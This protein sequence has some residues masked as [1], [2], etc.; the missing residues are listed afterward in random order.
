[1]VAAALTDA[2][3]QRQH[4]KHR[5]RLCAALCA[6]DAIVQ[7]PVEVPAHRTRLWIAGSKGWLQDGMI[8]GGGGASGS[9]YVLGVSKELCNPLVRPTTPREHPS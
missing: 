9:W 6:Q 3:P 4:V 5:T 7:R 1:M 8:K 2:G